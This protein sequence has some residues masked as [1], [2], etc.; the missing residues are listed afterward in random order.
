MLKFEYKKHIWPIHRTRNLVRLYAVQPGK[1]F[2]ENSRQVFYDALNFLQ[3]RTD[4]RQVN[5]KQEDIVTVPPFD[6][7]TFPELFL[8]KSTL[9][10]FLQGL[11]NLPL[12]GCVHSGIRPDS[13]KGYFFNKSHALEFIEE[14]YVIP[15]MHGDDLSAIKLYIQNEEV[16]SKFNFAAFFTKDRYGETRICLHPKVVRSKY[17]HGK[18]A[19]FHVT[20]AKFLSTITL[21]PS[22]ENGF[23]INVFPLIC[24][25]LLNK[26]RDTN[27]PSPLEAISGNGIKLDEDQTPLEAIDIV[28]V[29]TATPSS[30]VTHATW[31]EEF[32]KSLEEAASGQISPRLQ[33]AAFVMANYAYFDDIQQG[34]KA[35]LSGIFFTNPKAIGEELSQKVGKEVYRHFEGE[36]YCRPPSH[37]RKERF[38]GITEREAD[39]FRW[40][41]QLVPRE[42][43]PT[44]PTLGIFLYIPSEPVEN[45]PT[46][47]TATLSAPPRFIRKWEDSSAI[48]NIALYRAR[49]IEFKLDPNEKPVVR[50]DFFPE[51]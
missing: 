6:I 17:E 7:L 23:P 35:G 13:G 1:A 2:A 21:L 46:I 18:M 15:G 50:Y 22:N 25:D 26:P 34:E 28:S 30:G 37:I 27:L 32:R 39:W 47:F 31:K 41:D 11:S 38:A 48:S 8:P 45:T 14:L 36:I 51:S 33:N 24:A 16:N 19:E 42:Y 9:C 10:E 43:K 5:G 40:K 3:N 29:V 44:W 20:E 12:S 49:A 4:P